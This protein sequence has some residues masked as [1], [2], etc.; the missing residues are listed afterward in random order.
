MKNLAEFYF[1]G[2]PLRFQPQFSAALDALH[3][4]LKLKA[5]TTRPPK[6]LIFT[7]TWLTE[8]IPDSV[9]HLH[10]HSIHRSARS[11]ESDK[12][13]SNSISESNIYKDRAVPT[14]LKSTTSPQTIS[15]SFKKKKS[16]ILNAVID[17]VL[18]FSFWTQ[19]FFL[20]FCRRLLV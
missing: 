15:K 2:S 5:P 1:W 4:M 11:S 19:P 3:C 16:H 17:I 12:T 10:T 8:D 13:R 9:I 20:L 14:L 18:D 7:E 6:A